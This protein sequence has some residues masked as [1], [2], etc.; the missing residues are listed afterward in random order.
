MF[1]KLFKIFGPVV[2]AALIV[3]IL[4][5][6]PF[7]F[8]LNK[9][10]PD[11]QK[12]GAASL[13]VQ[14]LKGKQI[15]AAALNNN[16]VAFFGSSEWS[17]F[18]PLHPSVLAEKYNRSYQPFLLGSRGTQ[19]LEQFFT[20]QNIKDQLKGKK[21]VFSL[22][23]QWFVPSGMRKDAF[24]YYYSPLQTSSWLLDKNSSIRMNEYAAKRLLKM[25]PSESNKM[26]ND[27]INDV[28]KGKKLTSSQTNYLKLNEQI[29]SQE[30]R[31]FSQVFISDKNEQ[32]I[33]KLTKQLPDK[34]NYIELD[35][36]A[37]DLGRRKTSNNQFNLEDSFYKQNKIGERLNELRGFQKNMKFEKSVEY[38]DFQLVLNTFA[39]NNINA[40]FIIPPIN[41]K[42]Q[43][44]TGLPQA[45]IKKFVTK[46][47][48]QLTS[49][50][51]TNIVDLSNKGSEP[52]FMT[53]TIHYGW[54]GWLSFDQAVNPFLTTEQKKPHY[55]IKPEFYTKKW[56]Q[57]TVSQLSQFP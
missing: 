23:P 1:K 53:D 26:M 27:I 7:T 28:S 22:S 42:W 15:K 9:V 32:K 11:S 43:A 6:G 51:F 25:N 33:E 2:F 46:I 45:E 30:D 54:R 39:N 21:V 18:D 24:N 55:N 3:F 14:V 56:Q 47:R 31:F 16:Y 29:L 4:L 52:Y 17:R 38:S 37:T 50:G 10:S 36:L 48:Y 20:M 40:I 35:H 13:S 41:A 44:F 34:Y 19:S 5:A 57:A 49:Q 8:G 12:K